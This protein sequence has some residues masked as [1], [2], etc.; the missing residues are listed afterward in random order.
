M[1]SRN[2]VFWPS[3]FSSVLCVYFGW[4][5]ACSDDLQLYTTC[6]QLFSWNA[7]LSF[8]I[9]SSAFGSPVSRWD[10][11]TNELN[12]LLAE[13]MVVGCH[14]KIICVKISICIFTVAFCRLCGGIL[15]NLFL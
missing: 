11:C 2:V 10:L 5:I 15:L 6:M 7:S 9:S 14:M 3:L 12:I 1:Y 4:F 8:A 13:C